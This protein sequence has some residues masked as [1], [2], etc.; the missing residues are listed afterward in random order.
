MIIIIMLYWT[1]RQNATA[2]IDPVAVGKV[3]ISCCKIKGSQA[4]RESQCCNDSRSNTK[5]GTSS[6]AITRSVATI[7]CQQLATQL[8]DQRNSISEIY[9]V[10]SSQSVSLHD[11]TNVFTNLRTEEANPQ[12]QSSTKCRETDQ[13]L[14]NSGLAVTFV[15]L[16]TLIL[17]WLIDWWIRHSY[18]DASSYVSKTNDTR[19]G[20]LN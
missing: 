5:H 11:S 12:R 4:W 19:Y 17:F 2:Y 14:I 3:T 8:Q 9:N 20:L 6:T 15:T 16:V 7:T 18:V 1:V 13:H 10:T